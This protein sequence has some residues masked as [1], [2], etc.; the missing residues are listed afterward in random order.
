MNLNSVL[1]SS[2]VVL[3]ATFLCFILYEQDSCTD[4]PETNQSLGIENETLLNVENDTLCCFEAYKLEVL[5]HSTNVHSFSE[6]SDIVQMI[7]DGVQGTGVLEL[8]Y[9]FYGR[10]PRHILILDKIRGWNYNL[11]LAYLLV[12]VVTLVL[13]LVLMVRA[14]ARGLR[15]SLR[16]SEG[17]FYQ[18]QTPVRV[19]VLRNGRVSRCFVYFCVSFCVMV[20]GD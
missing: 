4:V 16:S 2:A 1:K 3:E 15:E 19:A 9:L 20:S 17:Q 18:V 5:E 14:A 6:P 10:Y 11:P 7:L 13:S 12:V 8:S